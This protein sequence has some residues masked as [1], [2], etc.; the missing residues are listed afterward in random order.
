MRLVSAILLTTV[1]SLSLIGAARAADPVPPAEGRG[2]GPAGVWLGTL[3][4]DVVKLRLG[5]ELAD[6]SGKLQGTMTSIDQAAAR[7]PI[8]EATF[9]DGSL[10]LQMKAIKATYVGKL[11]AD[12]SAME[13]EWAQGARK[14][15][16]KFERVEKL[17]TTARPQEPK[18]PYPYNEEEVTFE[19]KAANI[20]LAGTLTWP[21]EAGAHPAVVLISGSGP[22]DRD[23]ALMGHRPF[24]VLADHLTRNGIAVLRYDDRG[25]AKSQGD[26]SAAATPDFAADALAAVAYLKTRK[27]ID[28]K[29]IGL[30]G[31]SEG[32][33]TGPAA[34][35]Q[36]PD[37]IAFLVM[38]AG[39]G[40][41]MHE[42]LQRQA[43]D[44][45]KLSGMTP[46]QIEVIRARQR[47]LF[48]ALREAPDG[49]A[50]ETAVRTML[51]AEIA[52]V[53]EEQ[54]A[55]QSLTPEALEAQVKMLTSPWFRGLLLYDPHA[56]L[57]KV[58]CPVLAICGEKDM[59]VAAKE[60]LEGIRAGLE[61]GGNRDITI[62]ELPGL[63]HLLQ[64]CQTGAV[65][66]YAAIEETMNPE[67]LKVVS[68]WVRKRAGLA[69]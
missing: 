5:L 50:A 64:K 24:L 59:Q 14:F 28:P 61:A 35:A 47:K 60:N 15:P 2:K 34:I 8:D 26:Y 57:K 13:G 19:N 39:V 1:L 18:K 66:E 12:S 16:L 17:P 33:V 4:V 32:G 10:K 31:H 58:K 69:K 42:L 56:T 3:S 36:A 21:K 68:E 23:E 9:A 44:L 11:N 51:E 62:T 67:A 20:K 41:P 45:L 65:G 53:P 29:R 48:Q 38:V 37:D 54:R 22:Q 63:N 25:V 46:E 49:P 55:A 27:E 30:I 7:I 43:Q 6:V 52:K 40:V